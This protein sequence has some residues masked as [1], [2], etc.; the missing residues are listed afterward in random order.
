[1]PFARHLKTTTVSNTV[2]KYLNELFAVHGVPKKFYSDNGPQ[3]S[4]R[5]F[6]V[7]ADEWE[8]SHVT[9]SPKYPQSN[10]F[11]ERMVAVVISPE[12]I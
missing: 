7:F 10:E 11:C 8:F 4:S 12:D 3:Y 2:V 5:Q 9:S 1:M 6:K